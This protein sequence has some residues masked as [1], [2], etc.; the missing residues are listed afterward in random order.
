MEQEY[1]YL[2]KYDGVPIAVASD[3]DNASAVVMHYM[4]K[5]NKNS[6]VDI[7]L[8]EKEPIRYFTRKTFAIFDKMEEECQ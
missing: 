4:R 6:G 7:R 1:V 3:D 2:I 8:F 5:N